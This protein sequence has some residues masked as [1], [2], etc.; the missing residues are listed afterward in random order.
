MGRGGG[1]AA[2]SFSWAQLLPS[3]HLDARSLEEG[4]PGRRNPEVPASGSRAPSFDDCRVEVLC[5]TRGSQ[6]AGGQKCEGVCR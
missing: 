5:R 3:P 2:T 6:V 1:G 4:A